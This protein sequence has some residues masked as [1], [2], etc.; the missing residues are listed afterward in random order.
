MKGLKE[1]GVK[2]DFS[3][4]ISLLRGLLAG[5]VQP[6]YAAAVHMHQYACQPKHYAST[7]ISDSNPARVNPVSV[8][9]LFGLEFGVGLGLGLL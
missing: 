9:F 7:I 6:N 1:K 2:T 4:E 8:G 3:R 5:I